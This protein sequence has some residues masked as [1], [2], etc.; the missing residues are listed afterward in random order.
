M[1]NT[2]RQPTLQ[3]KN[4]T[5]HEEV[6]KTGDFA[7]VPYEMIEFLMNPPFKISSQQTRIIWFFIRKLQGWAHK[8]T[9][10]RTKDI[11]EGTGLDRSHCTEDLKY[12]IENKVLNRR[13]GVSRIYGEWIYSFNEETFGRVHAT[14]VVRIDRKTIPKPVKMTVAEIATSVLPSEPH[15]CSSISHTGV[16]ETATL[17]TQ[18]TTATAPQQVPKEILK[19][20]KEILKRIGIPE[21][22]TLIGKSETEIIEENRAKRYRQEVELNARGWK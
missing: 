3:Q 1:T 22:F 12:L 4:D 15:Q 5:E 18:I 6:K 21:S 9:A 20:D 10:A 14:N 16:V 13:A 8:E 7:A 2:I 17:N 11:V 19:R